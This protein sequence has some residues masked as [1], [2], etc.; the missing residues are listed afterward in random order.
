MNPQT[1][2]HLFQLL[3][4]LLIVIGLVFGIGLNDAKTAALFT[5]IAGLS[6]LYSFVSMNEI[7]PKDVEIVEK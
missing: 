4:V 5:A 2:A 6:F 1:E 7:P 3:G